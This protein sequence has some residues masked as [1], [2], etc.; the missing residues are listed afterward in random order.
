[1]SKPQPSNRPPTF[2]HL[3]S[4]KKPTTRRVD[5]VLDPDAAGSGL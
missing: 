1:M 2:D 4:R 5:I 3:R